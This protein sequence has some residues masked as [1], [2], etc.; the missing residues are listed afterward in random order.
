MVL[1][2]IA[3]VLGAK[4]VPSTEI[5]GTA[6][7]NCDENAQS[8]ANDRPD[9]F[10]RVASQGPR[11]GGTVISNQGRLETEIN[12]Q[13]GKLDFLYG[14]RLGRWVRPVLTRTAL[15]SLVAGTYY[16]TRFSRRHIEA[17][18]KSYGI[19]MNEYIRSNPSDYASFN[20]FFA[21]K[22]K[23]EL[24]PV[25][26][27][28]KVLVSPADSKLLV[29]ENIT[30]K[31]QF[32]VKG[33]KFDLSF[34]LDDSKLAREYKDGTLMIFRLS[35]QD[36]HRYHF[37]TQGVASEAKRIAGKYESVNPIVYNTGIDCLGENERRLTVLDTEEFGTV[38]MVAVGAL[39][40]GRVRETYTSNVVQPKGSEAGYFQFGGSTV[41]LLFKK[42]ALEVNP[43]FLSNSRQG[44]E[45]VV[46]MG[47]SIGVSRKNEARS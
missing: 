21:R 7:G 13:L 20:D 31:S 30:R 14:S 18:V 23:P 4:S 3:D 19:D 35:P 16:D 22:I 33:K 15:P 38:A 45:T 29:I 24:R 17:F 25:D 27:D 41:A 44:I 10:A 9:T 32:L 2:Q 34:F 1:R 11:A 28:P 42:G 40:V 46:K 39:C 26:S 6:A 36:Y 5:R 12:P 43:D 37:P 47:E 8:S